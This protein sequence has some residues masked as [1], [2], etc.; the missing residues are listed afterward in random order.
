[1]FRLAWTSQGHSLKELP[2][3]APF[4]VI[5]S[6]FGLLLNIICLVAQFYVAL[7]PV[8]GS[9]NAEAFFEAYLAA[10]IVIASYLV[11]KIW[12]KTPFRRP[13]TVDL[14]TGRRLFDTQQQSA[15]EEKAQRKTWSLWIRLYYKL[16]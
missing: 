14:E 13:S 7:F 16:C 4:G 12:Q 6:Y 15:E 8:G 3:V 10:P 11:W 9:P 5:G 1:M 2:F